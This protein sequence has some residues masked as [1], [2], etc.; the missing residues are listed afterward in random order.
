MGA[1]EIDTE[2]STDRL[3]VS[4]DRCAIIAYRRNKIISKLAM[5]IL[6]LFY[7]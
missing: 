1:D 6:H 2:D 5:I 7:L 3:C 4:S